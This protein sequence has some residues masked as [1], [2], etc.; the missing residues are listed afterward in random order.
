MQLLELYST[1][2][3]LYL[4]PSQ[5]ETFKILIWL[6]TV[7]KTVKIERLAAC[8]PLPIKYESRRKHIQRFLTLSSL[9][10]PLF[11]FPIIQ[12]IIQKEF[13]EGSRLIL[14][15]DRTQWQEN[16]IL[17]IAV[18]YKRRALP[19][20][21]HILNKRGSSNLS[22][23]QAVIRP[24][25]RLL[26]KYELV[27][28]GDREFHGVELSYWLKTQKSAES[29]YFIF[30]Q[31]QATHLKK[32]KGEYQKLSQTGV[33]PGTRLFIKNINITKNKGF[34]YFNIAAYW[35]RQYKGKLEKEPWYLLTNLDNF[36]E[37]IKIYRQ[38]MGIEAMF[39]DCKTGGYNLEGSRANTQRL[40]NLI[41]L[42]ALAY[43]AAVLKGKSI[44][45]SGCQQYISRLTEA[46]RK[47][48]RHSNFWVG[49]Y[50][51]LW[52]IGWEFLQDLVRELL[53]LNPHKLPSY[54]NGLRVMSLIKTT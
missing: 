51:N 53:D 23:Q 29:I 34:G 8:F 39:K 28:L 10:L 36:E 45:K 32:H 42:I 47:E 38:R 41:L 15:L 17:L 37:V 19:I 50:G 14:T 9:S 26:K 16:N 33:Y 12:S 1:H 40:T 6:L 27:L 54:Q 18:I 5:I 2:L 24:I 22:E 46:S 3:Q 20:Y 30:R 44:K 35:K 31:K 11:C 48:N 43:T 7:Q 4:T 13:T 52:I 21:W 49:I 25:L